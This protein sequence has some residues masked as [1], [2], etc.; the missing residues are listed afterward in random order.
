MKAAFLVM[1]MIL[2][3]P[4]SALAAWGQP[5]PVIINIA[6][7]EQETNTWYWPALLQQ[8]IN[9]RGIGQAPAQCDLVDTANA[10]KGL[11]GIN[12]CQDPGLPN[13]SRQADENELNSLISL[14]GGQMSEVTVPAAPQ[15]IY[16]YLMAGKVLLM[17]VEISGTNVKHFYMI[18]G[19]A[20]DGE[21]AMLTINDP[22]VPQSQTVKFS[23]FQN[24]WMRA[25]TVE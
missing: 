13:C 20:W 1:A 8:I 18:R 2:A 23:D 17:Q 22:A 19:L 11:T 9:W 24:T 25:F 10:Y 16:N 15:E 14:Y 5:D 12:C 4:S 6:N 3:W 21:E 7:E